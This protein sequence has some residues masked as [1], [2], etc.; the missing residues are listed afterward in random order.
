MKNALTILLIVLVAMGCNPGD[1]Q[2]TRS[3]SFNN[4]INNLKPDSSTLASEKP[5]H[6]PTTNDIDILLEKAKTSGS[7]EDLSA[8]WKATLHLTQWHFITKYTEKIEDRKP[9]IGVIDNQGW[10]FMFTDRQKAQEYGKTIKDGQFADEE[11]N[12]IVISMDTE[13]AIDYL[14]GLSSKGVYGM[15]QESMSSMAGFHQLQTC[16]L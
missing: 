14:M 15:R 3:N 2:S 11:G 5:M 1:T 12:V 9:F 8:L 4:D 13:K 7:N 6:Q 16:Q 10:V